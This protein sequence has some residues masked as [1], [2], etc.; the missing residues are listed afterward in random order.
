MKLILKSLS[1]LTTKEKI[2]FNLIALV[3]IIAVFVKI[4]GIGIL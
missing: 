1:I 3:S 2:L 4:L